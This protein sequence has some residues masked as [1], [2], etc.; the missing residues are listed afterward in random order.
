MGAAAPRLKV[1]RQSAK[2]MFDLDTI[3]EFAAFTRGPAEEAAII[4]DFLCRIGDFGMTNFAALTLCDFENPNVDYFHHHSLPKGWWDYYI[5]S[6]FSGHDPTFAGAMCNDLPFEW[7][8]QFSKGKFRPDPIRIKLLAES[9]EAGMGN[10]IIIPTGMMVQSKTC[11]SVSGAVSDIPEPDFY[12]LYILA[13]Y[14]AEAIK[15]RR[16]S[17]E[18]LPAIPRLTT[19]EGEILR[20]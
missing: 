15:S 9:R 5:D 8:K 1:F 17:N 13:I 12:A 6:D 7:R 4:D 2:F 11:V 16:R 14:F 20:W 3:T 19:R 18:L 10:G